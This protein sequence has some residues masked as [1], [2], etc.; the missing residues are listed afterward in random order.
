M[1]VLISDDHRSQRPSNLPPVST[2]DMRGRSPRLDSRRLLADEPSMNLYFDIDFSL[3]PQY[4]QNTY[5]M[6]QEI[7]FY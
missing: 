4:P 2:R 1:D 7:H 5:S 3:Q 6:D